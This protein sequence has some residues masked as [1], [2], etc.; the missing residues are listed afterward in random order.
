MKMTIL[1]NQNKVIR[2][3][4][5]NKREQ[6]HDY[7]VD[8]SNSRYNKEFGDEYI[9]EYNNDSVEEAMNEP[10]DEVTDDTAESSSEE[11]RNQS[12]QPYIFNP[13][14]LPK[15]GNES[16]DI[17]CAATSPLPNGKQSDQYNGSF[18]N[19]IVTI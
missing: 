16:D 14:N 8:K 17:N 12:F 2:N 9:N 11:K 18:R 13:I 6:N 19:I 15:S 5:S 10:D 7:K 4:E 1:V 3:H